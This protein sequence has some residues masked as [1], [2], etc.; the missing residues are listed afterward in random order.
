MGFG[1]LFIGYASLLFFKVMPPAMLVCAY[2]MYRG[3]SKLSEYGQY[4]GKAA[5]SAAFL[6]IYH[7]LYTV[8]W[9]V[10]A[11]GFFDGLFKSK[12]FV[13]C[14]DLLYYGLL[15]VFHIFMYRGIYDISK[16]CG[17]AKG[18]KRV[19]MSRVLMAMF[20]T[21][22]VISLPL[23]YF[24]IQSY[25]PLAH[26]ICEIVWLIYTVVFIYGCY[27]RIAN[28]EIIEEEEKKIAEFDAKYAYKRKAKKK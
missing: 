23:N 6:G 4:F 22:A 8:I 9:I 14:D 12:L 16:F 13:L 17:Y 2:V 26:F 11:L 10:S 20:Y 18:I 5:Y 27:M 28:D 24:G 19:Y 15:L 7:A 21:F 1:L 3:L 25:I